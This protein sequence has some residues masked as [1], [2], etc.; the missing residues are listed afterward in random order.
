MGKKKTDESFKCDIVEELGKLSTGKFFGIVSWNDGPGKF[1]IR[2]TY[3]SDGRSK[4]GS[5]ISLSESEMEE[6]IDLYAKYKKQKVDFEGI[7]GSA[8]AITEKRKDGYVTED[9]FIKVTKKRKK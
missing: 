3:E 1:D 8:S 4:L 6:V 5:G 9:G 7:F 2:R